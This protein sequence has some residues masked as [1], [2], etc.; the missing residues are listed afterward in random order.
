[1]LKK[2]KQKLNIG[3]I[4]KVL[5]KD[6][7]HEYNVS[8]ENLGPKDMTVIVYGKVAYV[9]E[10]VLVLANWINTDNQDV[11]RILLNEIVKVEVLV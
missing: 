2:L 6:H 8:K 3:N 11:Y 1:M 4:V 9:D 5:V 7:E 10:D